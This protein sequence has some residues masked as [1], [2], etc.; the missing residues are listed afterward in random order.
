MPKKEEGYLVSETGNWNVANDYSKLKI[1]RPLYH[2]DVY[3]EIA[4]FGTVD[5]EGEL[6]IDPKIADYLKIKGFRRL[7]YYLILVI[8]NSMFALKI[9]KENMVSYK[10]ELIRFRSVINLLYENKFNPQTKGNEVSIIYEK[11]NKALER[12]KE[13]KSLINEP[14]NKNDLIFT[15]KE[16]FDPKEYKR[17]IF[18]SATTKG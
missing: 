5:F 10:E 11:Y 13:L 12:V 18:E 16:E 8:D 4:E 17:Q 9:G 6:N 7:L 1:M 2:A 15:N 14:L 3:Q